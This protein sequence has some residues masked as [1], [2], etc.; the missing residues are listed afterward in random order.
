MN[1]VV[2]LQEDTDMTKANKEVQYTRKTKQRPT[3]EKLDWLLAID[4]F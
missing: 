1:E 4:A 3:A 2:T